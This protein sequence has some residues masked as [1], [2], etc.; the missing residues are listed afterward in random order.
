MRLQMEQEQQRKDALIVET[1]KMAQEREEALK[2][3]IRRE[4]EDQL[5]AR[6]AE[7]D[8]KYM[9]E[10]NQLKSRIDLMRGN[11]EAMQT[12]LQMNEHI[13]KVQQ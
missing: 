1:Q 3:Q 6:M 10:N 11:Y 5:K 12:N 4:M 9:A 2:E 8:S 13:R 7:V